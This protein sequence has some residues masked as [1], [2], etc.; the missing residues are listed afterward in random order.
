[1]S[2]VMALS[3]KSNVSY[4][5]MR[6]SS[7]SKEAMETRQVVVRAPRRIWDSLV[8]GIIVICR[9]QH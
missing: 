1:M 6:S 7:S 5:R 2:S 9:L 4:G 3:I 8:D